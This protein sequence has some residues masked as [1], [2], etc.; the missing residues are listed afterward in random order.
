MRNRYLN[1]TL[2]FAGILGLSVAGC[3]PADQAPEMDTPDLGGVWRLGGYRGISEESPPMTPAGQAM[4]DN[5]RPSYGARA[6]PPALGNDPTGT[7]TPL[8][9][10]RM[11]V[12]PRPME[13]VQLP[14][15]I[16]QL[17]EWTYYRRDIWIDGRELPED[18]APRWFGYS[19]GRWEGD[20]LVVESNGHDARTWVDQYGYPQTEGMRLEERW[21]RVGDNA[22][23]L[24]L[25]LF[26][27]EIYTEPW[28][29]DT[30]TLELLPT[31]DYPVSELRPDICAP[32]DEFDFNQRIRDPAGGLTGAQ[33]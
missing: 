10:V 20:T 22:M 2:M 6:I 25:T 27:P 13:F 19:V 29:S 8:G 1:L 23:E 33:P 4:F 3:A 9:L 11:L 7:C 28:M 5:N 16:V 24:T 26:D 15:R 14:G 21:R 18:P 17:W 31:E 30:R 12:Y 32:V